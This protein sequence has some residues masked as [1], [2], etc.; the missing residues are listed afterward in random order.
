MDINTILVGQSWTS[1]KYN[2]SKNMWYNLK[3][4]G[5]RSAPM[6]LLALSASPLHCFSFFS[7]NLAT[8]LKTS[9]S[10]ELT[11]VRFVLVFIHS[12]GPIL[13]T[14][15]CRL[16]LSSFRSISS[17]SDWTWYYDPGQSYDSIFGSGWFEV[18]QQ[19]L[20]DGKSDG[21][22]S[23]NWL[24]TAFLLQAVIFVW[25]PYFLFWSRGKIEFHVKRLKI[26]SCSW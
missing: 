12:F 4:C 7:R 11:E 14:C 22:P 8:N 15:S 9:L 2:C 20:P 21:H 18:L 6:P 19:F 24:T 25:L 17:S 26:I 5:H 13:L 10:I 3:K 23:Q 16:G 1:I